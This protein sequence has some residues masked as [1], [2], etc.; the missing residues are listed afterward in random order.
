[1]QT[2][3]LQRMPR[4]SASKKGRLVL[5]MAVVITVSETGLKT[6]LRVT[7]AAMKMAPRK[8]PRKTK[9]QFLRSFRRPILPAKRAVS[10]RLLP[11]NS[12]LPA[13]T[14]MASPAVKMQAPAILPP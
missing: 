5:A 9:N 14:T 7:S 12:S 3:T 4:R 11:V 2:R 6:P 10:M 8:L 1:M 13:M